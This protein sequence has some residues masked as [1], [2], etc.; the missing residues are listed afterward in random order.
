MLIMR[1]P[2]EKII[3][4]VDWILGAGYFS[5]PG[6]PDFK[7]GQKKMRAGDKWKSLDHGSSRAQRPHH[8]HQ[9]RCSQLT[10]HEDVEPLIK[11]GK[12]TTAYLP[13]DVERNYD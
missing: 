2:K 13:R 5:V 4:M 7:E 6:R 10:C 3:N 9:G 12:A 1:L 11:K 8:R